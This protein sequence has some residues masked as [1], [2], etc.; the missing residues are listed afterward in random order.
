M[1]NFPELDPLRRIE[2]LSAP[3]FLL[4]RIEASVETATKVPIKWLTISLASFVLL[5][6]INMFLIDQRL[7]HT[8]PA[9]TSELVQD[10]G[11]TPVNQL[12]HD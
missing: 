1:E 10:L 7:F 12:Y 2:R 3:P 11:L 6:S 8:K 5:F 9:H 4:T